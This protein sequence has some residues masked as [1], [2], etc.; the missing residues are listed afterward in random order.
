MANCTILGCLLLFLF[1]YL[2]IEYPDKNIPW[3]CKN[4]T[5]AMSDCEECLSSKVCTKC[6]TTYLRPEDYC[7][8]DCPDGYYQNSTSH[9]CESCDSYFFPSCSKCSNISC[10]ACKVGEGYLLIDKSACVENCTIDDESK[11]LF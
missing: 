7:S 2:L 3:S 9:T 6:S 10:E 11:I 5:E 8:T 1:I 4:C